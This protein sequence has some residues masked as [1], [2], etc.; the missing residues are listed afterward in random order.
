MASAFL[1]SRRGRFLARD[2]GARLRVGW[3]RWVGVVWAALGMCRVGEVAANPPESS[4]GSSVV[5]VFNSQLSESRELAHYYAERRGVPLERVVGLALPLTEAVSRAEYRERLEGPL[6]KALTEAGWMQRGGTVADRSEGDSPSQPRLRYLVLCHGVPVKILP[7][8]RWAEAGIESL[9]EPMRRNDAAVDSELATL[10]QLAEGVRLTGALVNPGYG[11]TN[12]MELGAEIGML[13]VARL[14]GP[15]PAGARRLVDRALEAERDGLWGRAY[16]DLRG[17][18]NTAYLMGERGLAGASELLRQAGFETVV[19]RQAATFPTAFPMSHIAFYAGWY[20]GTVSG[21]LARRQVEF[22]PGAFGYHLHSFSAQVLRSR[23]RGWAGPLVDRGVTATVGYV[24]EPY[25][26]T[27]LDLPAFMACWVHR[28]WTFGEAVYA[29]LPVLSWQATVVGDP[30]YRPFGR[31]P[32]DGPMGLRF[33]QLHADLEARTNSLIEWSCLQVVNLGLS[34]AGGVARSELL[35]Y[36]DE[37]SRRWSSAVLGEKLGVLWLEA[38]RIQAAIDAYARALEWQPSPQ[39]KVRLLLELASLRQLY[40]QEG[41]ALELYERLLD[42]VPDYP[43]R[44]TVLK[45]ALGLARGLQR[46]ERAA[47]LEEEL[48]RLG[49]GQ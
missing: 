11:R 5:V 34:G 28:G 19:D 8:A 6:V 38:G 22:M 3:A 42:E 13:M 32:P 37:Q 27:T 21:P 41:A 30:L 35:Q 20:D 12:A 14:D 43:D 1:W 36:L 10:P 47:K 46:A 39:Q 33:R 45:K 4:I 2:A 25:L 23:D 29:A 16:V 15:D 7:E 49:A 44:V 31:S 17:L 26:Q 24:E 48:R 18:T 9:P 40:V